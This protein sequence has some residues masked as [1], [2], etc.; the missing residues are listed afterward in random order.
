MNGRISSTVIALGYLVL[1]AA[2]A[3]AQD[4]AGVVRDTSGAVLPG[5]TV[6][7]ASP[8]LIEKVRAVVT[9]SSGQYKIVD[10]RPGVY[11]VTFTL[12]GFRAVRREGVE[13]T[14]GF[15]ASVNADLPVGA[16][17]ETVMVTAGSPTVDVQNVRSQNVFSHEYLETVPTGKSG[18]GYAS[19]IV[20]ATAAAGADVGGNKGEASSNLTIHGSRPA[21]YKLLVDGMSYNYVNA[22][23]NLRT[24]FINHLAMEEIALETG[25]MSAESSTGGIQQNAI[26]KDGGNRYSGLALA[27]YSGPGLVANNLTDELRARGVTTGVL[28]KRIYDAGAGLGG[29]FRQD[30]L[31][32]YL[33]SRWWGAG[34][35]LPANYFNKTP[36]TLFY[37]PDLSRPAFRDNTLRDHTARLT[38]QAA[39]KHKLAAYWSVQRN[40]FCYFN[41]IANAAPEAGLFSKYSQGPVSLAQITW[42]NPASNRLLFDVGATYAHNVF[43]ILPTDGVSRDSIGVTELSTGYRYGAPPSGLG[44]STL[45]ESWNPQINVRAAASYVT[46]SHAFKVGLYF[47]QSVNARDEHYVPQAIEYAFRKPT[48]EAAPV[49]VSITQW[50]SP[51]ATISAGQD[52]AL[53]AL[54]QWTVRRLTLNLGLRVDHMHAWVPE[55]TRPAGRFV[56][57][58]KVAKVDNVPNWRDVSPRLG[59][60][61]DLFGNGKTAI[62]ASLGRYVVI[63]SAPGGFA[64]TPANNPAN[65]LVLSATRVW[66]DVNN[67]YVPQESELGPLSNSAFG[68]VVQNTRYNEEVLNGWGVRPDNWQTS[69]AVQHELRPGLGAMIA[70]YRTSYGHFRVTDN[71]LV[72]P[73]DY[74]PFCV[75]APV[76]SRLPGGG[77]NQLCGLS[78]IKPA[79]FGAVNNLVTHAADFGK[80]TEVFNGAELSL[81]ARFGDGGVINGGIFTGRTTTDSCFTVDSP[82]QLYQCAVSDP[83][84]QLKFNGVYPLP[85]NLQVAWTY[86]NLQGV[87]TLATRV[88]TNAELAPSLGRNL[89]SC[90]T[91]VPC[92]GTATVNLIEPGTVFEDRY[93]QLDL[94]LTKT[95]R[96]GRARL[97]GMADAYNLFNA[98]AVTARNNAYGPTWGRPTAIQVG[99]LFKFGGQFDW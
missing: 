62:K 53:Y 75:A 63:D 42:T 26:P 70:Y 56:P 22:G 47:M 91:R 34:E 3:G 35:Y 8:A 97:Q 27:N 20:G 23:G 68:T 92:N 67:D 11:A 13:L 89:G 16:L 65:A 64:L 29:P 19:L 90:G 96:M 10:L 44:I 18:A 2:T 28:L 88:Y 48:P 49:P 15:T 6:E 73:G 46:G 57:E 21:D 33:A 76:D 61:Y 78:D 81:A 14:T 85:W 7:A 72:T 98:S 93:T 36:N 84:T 74:S 87:P 32:F 24:Y 54:D 79:A 12:P 40:C 43:T 38:W 5:V 69:A 99:R 31:W 50:A 55:Q 9:D 80:Q 58:L 86:Q 82:Q 66:N 71:L 52:S 41:G 39:P 77:G 25:G 30:K 17:E 4:I 60:A 45:G 95:I 37:T 83:S 51:S 59:A 1:V 94:R